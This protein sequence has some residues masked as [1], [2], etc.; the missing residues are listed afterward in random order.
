VSGI[1]CI[2]NTKNNKFYIGQTIRSFK[3]RWKEH[4]DNLNHPNPKKHHNPHLQASWDKYGEDAFEFLEI[5]KI[6]KHRQDLMDWW[7]AVA[8]GDLYNDPSRCYNKKAGGTGGAQSEETKRKQSKNAGRWNLDKS[9]SK[10][11][12][13][14]ISKNH[15]RYWQGKNHTDETK[16]NI[17]ETKKGVPQSEESKRKRSETMKGT[18]K[19]KITCPWCGQSG[20]KPTMTRWHM[21]NCKLKETPCP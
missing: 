17:S 14:N 8:I 18:S 20:G 15:A 12:R 19:P 13:R 9:L 6:D 4:R 1:Y 5:M 7:E 2:R 16:R 3:K 11:H 10:A 21:D